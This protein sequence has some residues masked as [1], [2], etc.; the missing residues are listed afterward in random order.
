MGSDFSEGLQAHL[1]EYRD[2][3]LVQMHIWCKLTAL[4][5]TFMP[6][7]GEA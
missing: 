5:V 4:N 1:V 7:S 6:A 2:A 3:Y